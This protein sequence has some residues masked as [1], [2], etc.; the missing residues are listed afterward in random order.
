MGLTI[1]QDH[2]GTAVDAAITTALCTGLLNA[3]SSGIGGGGFMV[4]RVPEG[5]PLPGDKEKAVGVWALD[6]REV[7]PSNGDKY[8]FGA[9][10]AGREAAQVGGLAI[11]VPG[12]L[13]GL[14]AGKS[15]Q[16]VG[17]GVMLTS[18]AHKLYGRLPWEELVMPVVELSKGWRC[19]RE[20]ARRLRVSTVLMG[21]VDTR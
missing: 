15:W 21:D 17:L 19:S 18:V 6:F 20:L 3:M 5:A 16:Y 10:H 8:M 12:E 2:N 14:E 1:L 9:N 13:R 11:G 7:T 4:V